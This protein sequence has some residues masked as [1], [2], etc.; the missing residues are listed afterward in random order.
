MRENFEQHAITLKPEIGSGVHNLKVF[1]R[2][3]VLFMWCGPKS[4]TVFLDWDGPFPDGVDLRL[5]EIVDNSLDVAWRVGR[6]RF[7]GGQDVMLV[8]PDFWVDDYHW[9]E[10][11]LDNDSEARRQ[12]TDYINMFINKNT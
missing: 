8:G 6:Y 7:G 2:Y 1:T 11:L 12:Y 4:N 3:R 5:C 9:Y 10:R